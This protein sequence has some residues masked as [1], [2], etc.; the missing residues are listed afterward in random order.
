MIHSESRL[1]YLFTHLHLLSSDSFSSLIF[2]PLLFSL[3]L[4]SSL[5]F[6]F[7][8]LPFL[9]SSSSLPLLFSSLLWLFP[10]LRFHLSILSEVWLL[11]FLRSYPL[12][13]TFAAILWSLVFIRVAASHSLGW[14]RET[15]TSASSHCKHINFRS[16]SHILSF[17]CTFSDSQPRTHSNKAYF[18]I[19]CAGNN[20][21]SDN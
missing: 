18:D 13:W 14:P 7:S 4:F 17:S 15:V 6:P 8:S 20:V 1:F 9:F 11:S 10:P 21:L 2:S 19:F 16:I 5:P 12:L 3:L